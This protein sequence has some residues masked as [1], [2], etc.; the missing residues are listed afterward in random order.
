MWPFDS[1]KK[2]ELGTKVTIKIGGMHCSSC[3]LTIDDE[4]EELAGVHEA[5]S[6]YAKGEVIV[7]FDPQK[8]TIEK[9]ESAIS[10]LGYTIETNTAE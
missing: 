10:K 5:R 3:A 2:P 8:V 9:L 6:S 4:L 1:T 7:R